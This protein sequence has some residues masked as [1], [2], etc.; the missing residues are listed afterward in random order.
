MKNGN[1]LV[2][3]SW[4]H[5]ELL[6][7]QHNP[8]HNPFL[9]THDSFLLFPLM[10]HSELQMFISMS[11]FYRFF[12]SL[13]SYIPPSLLWFSSPSLPLCIPFHPGFF[14]FFFLSCVFILFTFFILLSSCLEC[15]L[16]LFQGVV[17]SFFYGLRKGKCWKEA[18]V[19]AKYAVLY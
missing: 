14:L 18:G 19:L 1:F 10:L 11:F 7:S 3:Q 5:E 16:S 4:L 13:S 6:S 15:L 8:T 12:A 2:E 9:R 17:L